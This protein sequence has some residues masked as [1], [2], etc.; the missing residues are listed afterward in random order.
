MM[1]KHDGSTLKVAKVVIDGSGDRT[2]KKEFRAYLRR[3]FDA[4]SIRSVELKDSRTD[5]L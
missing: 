3:H 1:M 4:S 2:F 5:E